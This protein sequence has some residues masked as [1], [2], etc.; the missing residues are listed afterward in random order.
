MSNTKK[1]FVI[2]VILCVVSAVLFSGSLAMYLKA[3]SLSEKAE[4]TRP[5]TVTAS[6]EAAATTDETSATAAPTEQQEPS[7]A[8][9]A[10]V[11]SAPEGM[12]GLLAEVGSSVDSLREAGCTQLVTVDAYGSS[13][14]INYYSLENNVWTEDESLSCSG[15]VGSNGVTTDMHEGGHATPWGLYGIGEAFYLYSK[16]AT[17]LNTFE[18]TN[19]TY[20][21]D[22]PDSKYYNQRVVGT[23]DMDW[24]SAE[25]MASISSYEY[26]FVINYNLAAEYNKGSAIF[27]HISSVPTAGCIG[28]DVD[29][30]MG[31][32]E[33]LDAAR[34]PQILIV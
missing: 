10:A 30:V 33:K 20:W 9:T 25:H 32:L 15:Y 3:R 16:P 2:S 12:I 27:F 14:Q 22:D 17:G 18:I 4:A 8:A 19:D 5:T 13:A 7:E 21:V 26:G 31:Y 29:H 11:I 28:T 1:F 24:K 6:T 34:N 23:A